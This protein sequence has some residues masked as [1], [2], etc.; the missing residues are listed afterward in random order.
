MH[1]SAEL[2]FNDYLYILCHLLADFILY[3]IIM[4]TLV[5][6]DILVIICI[7]MN[8]FVTRIHHED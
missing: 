3:H 4:F 5:S 7:I 2:C 8:V 1:L 6:I